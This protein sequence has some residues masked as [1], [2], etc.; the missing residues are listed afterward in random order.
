MVS[1]C[2]PIARHPRQWRMYDTLRCNLFYS[3]MAVD[4]DYIL[5]T[6]PGCAKNN[7]NHRHRRKLLFFPATGPVE[8]VAMDIVGPFLKNTQENQYILIISD[9]YS[10]LNW[11]II[12]F[13]TTATHIAIF[14]P[15]STAHPFWHL[16]VHPDWPWYSICLQMLCYGVLP[17]QW[18]TLHNNSKS[19]VDEQPCQKIH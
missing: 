6:C 2:P 17:P 5:S 12:T 4:I 16:D 8:I 3:H 1:C 14:F 9:Q 10:K 7:P 18:E 13:K 19:F 11:A 15:R